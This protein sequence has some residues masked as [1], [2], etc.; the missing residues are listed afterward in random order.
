M[1]HASNPVKVGDI[2]IRG[3]D[4]SDDCS[5][6]KLATLVAGKQANLIV[7]YEKRGE[8]LKV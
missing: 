2:L 8:I 7:T 3:R 5:L 4:V 1:T 6:K